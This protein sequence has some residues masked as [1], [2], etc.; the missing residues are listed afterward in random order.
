MCQ[1]GALTVPTVTARRRCSIFHDQAVSRLAVVGGKNPDI[2]IQPGFIAFMH[3]TLG[4]TVSVSRP[5]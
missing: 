2:M 3:A 1:T 4:Y 5:T